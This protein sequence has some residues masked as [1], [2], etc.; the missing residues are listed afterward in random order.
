MTVR[1]CEAK[2]RAFTVTVVP[3]LMVGSFVTDTEL[4]ITAQS[5]ATG[6]PAGVQLPAAVQFVLVAP[7]HCLHV[8]A[9]AVLFVA[10]ATT[11]ANSGASSARRAIRR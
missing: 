5:V 3:V 7:V 9:V 6:A 10:S 2:V 8:A 4:S 1:V 11:S